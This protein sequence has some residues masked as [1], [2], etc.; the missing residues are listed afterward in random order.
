[1]RFQQT[2]LVS[3]ERAVNL[4]PYTS[5][6]DAPTRTRDRDLPRFA[7][8]VLVALITVLLGVLSFH[9]L[10]AKTIW[11]DE[12]ASIGIARLGWGSF[13]RILWRREANMSLYYVAL[14][15][16]LQFGD[17]PFF[18][19]ALSVFFALPTVSAVFLL[20]K[21]MFN[22]QTGI[23][24]S[25]LLAINAFELS[26][27]QQA[28]SYSLMIALCAWSSLYF[29]EYFEASSRKTR[30]FYI[31]TCVLAIYAHFFSVLLIAT[32][33]LWLRLRD[34]KRSVLE[35]RRVLRWILLFTSPLLVF[36]AKTGAGPLRWI[37]R[38]G[39][40]EVSDLALALCG[41]GGPI[42]VLAYAAASAAI[43]FSRWSDNTQMWNVR[44]LVLWLLAPIATILLASWARPL[45]LTRYFA[46]CL[47]A[48]CL[49]AAAG[50]SRLRSK[51]AIAAALLLFGGLSLHGDLLYYQHDFD[52]KR[53]DWRVATQYV[54]AN[55]SP[56]DAVLF[57]VAMAR[58]PY[59]YYRS[60]AAPDSRWP[61][62]VYPDR[63]PQLTARDLLEKPDYSQI[64]QELSQHGRVWLVVS[65]NGSPG[66]DATALR[67]ASLASSGRALTQ[68]LNFNA[69][70]RIFLYERPLEH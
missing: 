36:I 69:G 56:N 39:W 32:Q 35:S 10:A 18:V 48:L 42:L 11:F 70:L 15:F 34:P 6:S 29:L 30:A 22:S 57:H 38:P 3:Q 7:S 64:A 50:I 21:R 31:G 23:I 13:A 51:L 26:H 37:A 55:A 44:F 16:W 46:F 40:R 8:P 63:G 45:F 27:A 12:G 58:L 19:R 54:R 68:T 61:E 25:F 2:L 65:Q 60:L 1:M 20:G 28:R 4:A 43:F 49:L 9:D 53:E 66:M 67:F 59:E 17:S 62:V 41:N 5:A 33:W 14:R 47:P 52:L 24:A